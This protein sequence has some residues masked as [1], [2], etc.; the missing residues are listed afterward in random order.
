MS[1]TKEQLGFDPDIEYRAIE[2]AL[3]ET[4]RGRWFLS[5]FGRRARRLDGNALEEAMK[6]LNSSLRQPPA[7][8]GALQREVEMLLATVA[9][10]RIT[11]FAK[12]TPDDTVDETVSCTQSI[13]KATEDLHEMAWKLDGDETNADHCEAIARNVSRIYALSR[14]QGAESERARAFGEA[15]DGLS[16]RLSALLQ[17]IKYE[18]QVDDPHPDTDIAPRRAGFGN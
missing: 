12:S 18:M 14:L 4:A 16:Q 6:K 13:L 7:L 10:A 17:T 2:T 8:L 5:E 3:L 9:D 1:Q 15:L 11:N